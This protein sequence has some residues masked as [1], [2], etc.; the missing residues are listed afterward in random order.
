MLALRVSFGIHRGERFCASFVKRTANTRHSLS[1]NLLE[2]AGHDANGPPQLWK[3]F[4]VDY[5]AI[6]IE[7]KVGE[8]A[9]GTVYSCKFRSYRAAIKELHKLSAQ[10]QSLLHAFKKEIQIMSALSHPCTIRFYGWVRQ[11]PALVM[12]LAECNLLD[13][14]SSEAAHG[15]LSETNCI[16]T[17]VD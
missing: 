6:D 13:F 4:C 1:A 17:C 5:G 16:L 9:S 10:S 2:N 7:E 15:K 12:E 3:R 8:G 14:Y 11:P